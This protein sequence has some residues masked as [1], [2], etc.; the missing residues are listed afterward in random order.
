MAYL[1]TDDICVYWCGHTKD[2]AD[3]DHDRSLMQLFEKC[4]ECDLHLSV[5]KLQFKSSVTF[6]GHKLI[7][8]YV[9]PD[10]ARVTTI[11]R[12]PIPTEKAR[13]QQFLGMCQ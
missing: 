8:K 5:K 13:V 4:S 2:E 6:M 9:K 7:D 11:T 12:M 3:I 1:I 10:P